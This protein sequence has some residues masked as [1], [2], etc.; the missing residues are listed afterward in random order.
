VG[1]SGSTLAMELLA[2]SENTFM[3]AEPYYNYAVSAVQ[4]MYLPPS[5]IPSVQNLMDCTFLYDRITLD[6]VFWFFA[7][8]T[9]P[10]IKD[11]AT[12]FSLCKNGQLDS[13][14]LQRRCM[15]ADHIVMK[16]IRFPMLP[17]AN[18]TLPY[19]PDDVKVLH[20]VRAP[21]D[22][23]VS[24]RKAGWFEG[25]VVREHLEIICEWIDYHRN[26]S[27]LISPSNLL[28]MRY[29]DLVL[30]FE[31]GLE[32]MFA[33]AEVEL[34]PDVRVKA[35]TI[36]RVKHAIL[37]GKTFDTDPAHVK[38]MSLEIDACQRVSRDFGYNN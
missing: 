19:I 12:L 22:V 21:W 4:P 24:Q 29:E 5:E 15:R 17:Q 20:F 1:R 9:I 34:T 10:W 7:C 8:D 13:A 18:V 27:L 31:R 14:M 6:R 38:Q 37:P 23:V 11:N 36:K 26:I 30:D 28:V 25:V 2:S 16:V 3:I 35:Q 33:F 32:T